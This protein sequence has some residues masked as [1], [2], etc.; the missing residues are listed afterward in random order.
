MIYQNVTQ[1]FISGLIFILAL[2]QPAAAAIEIVAKVN[3]KPITNYDVEQRV[4]FLTAITNI[5]LNDSNR[6][7]LETD[8]LQMLIDEK[9]KLQAAQSIDPN[10]AARSL[11]TARGLVDSSFQQNGKSGTEILREL[12]L[13]TASIQQKFVTDLA[14]VSFIQAN[15]GERLGDLDAKI[16]AEIARITENAKQPQIRLSELVLVPEPDRPLQDLSLIHISEPTRP[17]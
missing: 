12:N 3:G 15:F 8:A 7:R 9:L 13:D 5:Q 2:M 6:Q 17:Y 11:P 10:I 4:N 14:W 16:D 1:T